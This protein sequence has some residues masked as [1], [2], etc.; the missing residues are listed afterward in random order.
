MRR[1]GALALGAVLMLG[2]VT[3]G[4]GDELSGSVRMGGAAPSGGFALPR[5]PKLGLM[6]IGLICRSG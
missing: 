3:G 1:S 5:F 2:G 6:Q 4:R